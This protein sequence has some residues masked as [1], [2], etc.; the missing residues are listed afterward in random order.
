VNGRFTAAAFDQVS[1]RRASGLHYEN[2]STLQRR[3]SGND[4][5]KIFPDLPWARR[6]TTEGRTE[7]LRRQVQD[8]RNRAAANIVRQRAATDRVRAAL[9]GWR[10]GT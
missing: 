7:R 8:V 10:R 5:F 1:I 6:T 3:P 4:L 2:M 9:A